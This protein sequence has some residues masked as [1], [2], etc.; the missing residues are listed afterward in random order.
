M[1]STFLSSFKPRNLHISHSWG[2][3]LGNWISDFC[4]ADVYSEN[5]VLESAT[6]GGVIGMGYRLLRGPGRQ[7]LA[8]WTLQRPIGTTTVEHGEYRAMLESIIERFEIAHVYHSSF[9]GHSLD[10][11]ALEVPTTKVYHDFYPWCP[12]IHCYFNDPCSSCDETR[13]RTCAVENEMML[14]NRSPDGWVEV[15]ERFL[16]LLARPHVRHVCP[17]ASTARLLRRLEPSFGRIP[18]IVIEHGTGQEKTYAFGG[19]AE[20]RRLRAGVVGRLHVQKGVRVLERIFDLARSIADLHFIGCG[21]VPASFHERWATSIVPEYAPEE[22][23]GVF[24]RHQ[25]DLV[26]F[27]SVVPETF[28]YALSEVMAHCIPPVARRLG[29]FEDRIRDGENGFLLGPTDEDVI[30]FLLRADH[31]RSLLRQVADQLRGG[32][33]RT[34]GDMVND[35]YGLR[36]D[37]ADLVGARLAGA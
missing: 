29:S 5:L 8:S 15:R 26:L 27:L 14:F 24:A 22:L 10:A 6:S 1:E 2:G 21:N 23:G 34:V 31:D 32:A 13:L 36:A 25:L 20:G 16:E 30:R 19:A 37:Y 12:A 35:Y 7:E 4:R 11:L 28:S 17:S 9:L 33:T 3:G 18:F